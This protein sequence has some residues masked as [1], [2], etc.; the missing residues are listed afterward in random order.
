MARLERERRYRVCDTGA[1]RT[2]REAASQTVKP[3]GHAVPFSAGL[4]RIA[5]ILRMRSLL[6][7]DSVKALNTPGGNLGVSICLS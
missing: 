2:A 6:V 3:H 1:R 4:E 5:F 7:R